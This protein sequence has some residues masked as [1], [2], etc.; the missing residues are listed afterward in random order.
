[1]ARPK[2]QTVD[3]FPH[4]CNHKKTIYILENKY[5]NDG[6]S[7][8]F[9]LLEILGNTAGHYINYNGSNEGEWEFLQAK[10]HLSEEKCNEILNML[11][12]LGAIDNNLWKHRIVCSQNF[13]DGIADVYRNRRVEIPAMPRFYNGK[14]ICDGVSTEKSTQTKLKETKL[15]KTILDSTTQDIPSFVTDD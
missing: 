7:F 3:Y 5:G 11:A 13:L 8:W 10:T 2:K 4:Y 6:Y 12:K 14:L 9:K 1:M 15:N